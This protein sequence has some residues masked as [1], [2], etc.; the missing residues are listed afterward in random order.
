MEKE[1]RRKLRIERRK[2]EKR[3]EILAKYEER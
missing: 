1:E 3:K 2:E